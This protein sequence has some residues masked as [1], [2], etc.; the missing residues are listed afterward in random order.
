MGKQHSE[1]KRYNPFP[2]GQFDQD[3]NLL[4]EFDLVRSAA[5]YLKIQKSLILPLNKIV[6]HIRDSIRMDKLYEGFMW[7]WIK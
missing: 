4:R 6:R 7:A 2:V 5:T 1:N 3:K